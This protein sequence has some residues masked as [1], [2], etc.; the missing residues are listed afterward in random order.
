MIQSPSTGEPNARQRAAELIK[1]RKGALRRYQMRERL[2]RDINQADPVTTKLF[3]SLQLAAWAK[4]NSPD[5]DEAHA[6][7]RQCFDFLMQWLGQLERPDLPS[8]DLLGER[9]EQGR[10][11]PKSRLARQP[12]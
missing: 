1:Q 8:F 10:A 9:K 5:Q 6:Y 4:N 11:A 3:Q 2:R 7:E 12:K